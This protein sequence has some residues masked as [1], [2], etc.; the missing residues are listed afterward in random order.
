MVDGGFNGGDV[1]EKKK[2]TPHFHVI[3]LDSFITLFR[4][5]IRDNPRGP[6]LSP[7]ILNHGV[8]LIEKS[9]YVPT[10]QLSPDQPVI[11]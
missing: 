8:M 10:S 3:H 9:I 7:S 4:S 6:Q 1:K 5:H 2:K 11:H